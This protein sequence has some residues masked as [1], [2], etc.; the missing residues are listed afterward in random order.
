MIVDREIETEEAPARH[1]RSLGADVGA[2][3]D[4][5]D[6]PD[7]EENEQRR[8]DERQKQARVLRSDRGL[9]TPGGSFGH[10]A[11]N[12]RMVLG[13]GRFFSRPQEAHH[14]AAVEAGRI[15]HRVH[16]GSLWTAGTSLRPAP[17]NWP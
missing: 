10:S 12:L 17:W 7:G 1:P 3:A 8:P 16:P 5:C 11:S 13:V 4:V 15:G 6:P 14:V 9:V 2:A